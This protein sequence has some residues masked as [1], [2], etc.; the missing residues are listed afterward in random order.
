MGQQVLCFAG[1]DLKD[2][3][4]LGDHELQQY[5]LS[6]EVGVGRGAAWYRT[7]CIHGG[8]VVITGLSQV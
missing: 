7:C 4:S 8:K 1:K 2:H 3:L 5:T 6:D